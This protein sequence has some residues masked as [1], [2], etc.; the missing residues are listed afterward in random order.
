MRTRFTQA[1]PAKPDAANQEIVAD[2]VVQRHASRD[3]VAPGIARM[4]R[5][6]VVPRQ[7]IDRLGFDEGDLPS[8]S[9]S[10]RVGPLGPKV[11][12]SFEPLAGDCAHALDRSHRSF[13]GLRN[14]DR[15]HFAAPWPDPCHGA[16]MGDADITLAYSG[17]RTMASASISTR[18]SGWMKPLTRTIVAAGRISRNNS[19]WARP[20]FSES[21]M[22]ARNI[23]VSARRR[24]AGHPLPRGPPRFSG[25]C[26]PLDRMRPHEP[27]CH[28][29]NLSRWSPRRPR[30][31]RRGPP[32]SIPRSA[33]RVPRR[34]RSFASCPVEPVRHR[35]DFVWLMTTSQVWL[36]SVRRRGATEGL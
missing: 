15:A 12:V 28:P 20:T 8:R 7:R 30:T 14:V 5:D 11:S 36:P 35:K 9:R 2:E 6:L 32:A 26:G 22:S 17:S 4:D 25:R 27:R 31:V 29:A 13:R 23:R 18:I 10:V 21:P 16:S 33:P 24:A 1:D 34:P 3:D 19:A